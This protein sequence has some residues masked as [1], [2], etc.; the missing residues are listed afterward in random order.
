MQD[1]NEPVTVERGMEGVILLQLTVQ[2]GCFIY[3]DG[4][5][6]KNSPCSLNVE[7]RT[8]QNLEC[9]G[10]KTQSLCGTKFQNENWNTVRRVVVQHTNDLNYKL[11]SMYLVKL[12]T[13]PMESHPIWSN[14]EIPEVKVNLDL[15]LKYKIRFAKPKRMHKNAHYTFR[16]MQIR[17]KE[18]L[19][20]WKGKACYSHSD[21]HMMTFDGE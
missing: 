14:V 20:K 5:E 10:I 17:V 21:P 7:L 19:S 13:L 9:G 11:S 6:Q 18:N 2:F 12:F 16:N 15:K 3:Y 8:L 1:L 4:D